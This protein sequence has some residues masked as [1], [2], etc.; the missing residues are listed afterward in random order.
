MSAE[1]C[2]P[3]FALFKKMFFSTKE[4]WL[5]VCVAVRLFVRSYW[6]YGSS[7]PCFRMVIKIG[8]LLR[9]LLPRGDKKSQK[10]RLIA[11]A[12]VQNLSPLHVLIWMIFSRNVSSRVLP[13][14]YLCTVLFYLQH[15]DLSFWLC[16]WASRAIRICEIRVRRTTII[17]LAANPWMSATRLFW[18][19]IQPLDC[20]SVDSG[21]ATSFW[22]CRSVGGCWLM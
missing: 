11:P 16:A 5:S 22:H 10:L 7:M 21:S 2:I 17:I 4:A 14:M 15:R 8:C 19:T 6:S 18:N 12:F 20:G 1:F 9:W 3:G 13:F